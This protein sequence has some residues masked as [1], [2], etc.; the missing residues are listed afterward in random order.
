MGQIGVLDCNNFFVS[1][2]RLFRPDLR[3]TPVVVLSSNDGCV[4]A[5]SKEIKDM[6]V[7]M[8]IPLFQIKDI[9]R[10]EGAVTFS[11][12]FTLYRDISRRVFEVM[13]AEVGEVEQYSID[14]AFF[15][16][17]G[18]AEAVAKNLK[19]RVEQ[20]VGIPVSIGIAASKTRAKYA[21]TRAKKTDG[22]AVLDE[23][24]WQSLAA[25]IPLHEL[26]GVGSKLSVRYRAHGLE[27]VSDFL[28]A[29]PARIA[30]LFGVEGSRL[31]AEL[32]GAVAL[33]VTPQQS[34]QKS[35]MSTRSF[36]HPVV[37]KEALLDAISYHLRQSAAELRRLGAVASRVT[38]LARTSRHG[39]YYGQGFTKE[40]HLQP[41]T[42]DAFTLMRLAVAAA[43]EGF[44]DGVPYKKAGVILQGLSAKAATQPSLF[45]SPVPDR[46]PVI[47]A[48]DALN[49]RYGSELIALGSRLKETVWQTKREAISPAYTTDWKQLATAVA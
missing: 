11:S 38:V 35:I 16:V 29:D 13:V 34:L 40:I 18:D 41:P 30:Q 32:S 27:T 46:T 20:C 44:R 26:W 25:T 21:N 5:R 33:P 37:Q 42:S 31:L 14:E 48:V 19:A 7:P 15:K 2:E 3:R 1:C 28:A 43:E 4:V 24:L 45:S 10:K 17:S 23:P 36:G 47:N 12:N 39:E 22:I 9:L 6:G 8:G 49:R